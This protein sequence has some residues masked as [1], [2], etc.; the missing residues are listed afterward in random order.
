MNFLHNTHQIRYFFLIVIPLTI[1]YSIAG[2]TTISR[3]KE[4]YITELE[5]VESNNLEMRIRLF[6][7]TLIGYL[8]DA[9][10]LTEATGKAIDTAHEGEDVFEFLTTIFKAYACHHQAYDQIRYIDQNGMEKIRI[11]W[12]AAT[13]ARQAPENE[14]QYKGDRYYFLRGNTLPLGKVYLSALDLNIERGTIEIPIKP[15]MRIVLPVN[16]ADG[17]QKGILVMNLLGQKLIDTLTEAGHK[18]SGRLFLVNNKGHWLKGPEP[19]LEWQF[20]YSSTPETVKTKYPDL[21]KQMVDKPQGYWQSDSGLFYYQNISLGISP[22][23]T[24][25]DDP[26]VES[27]E[28]LQVINHIPPHLLSP[29]WMKPVLLLFFSGEVSLT[30]LSWIGA[31]LLTRRRLAIKS[32]AAKEKELTTIA[33]SVRDAI[34]MIDDSGRA[35]FWNSSAEELFGYPASEVL[36]RDIHQFITPKEQRP[37]ASAGLEEF[38]NTGEG[39][40]IGEL[41]KVEA[42]RK[43]G[44]RFPAE[45]N[46]NAIHMEDRWWAVGVVRDISS[47]ESIEKKAAIQEQ[48][49]K[50][51]VKYVPAAVAMFDRQICYIAASNRWYTDY[52]LEGQEIIGKS[53]YDIFPE[54]REMKEWLDLHQRCLSGEVLQRDEDDFIRADGH[55][56]WLRWE[57]RPWLD[58][59]GEIGGI[60]MLTEVITQRKEME[61]RIMES[62]QQLRRAMEEAPHPVM[63]RTGDGEI[64]LI[65]QPWLDLSGF[66][67]DQ[68]SNVGEWLER[69]YRETPDESLD[70]VYQLY[71]ISQKTDRGETQIL[72]V[73]GE[74]RDWEVS[75]ATIGQLPDGRLA[76]ITMAVDV[77]ERKKAESKVLALNRELEER[78]RQRTR[79]LEDLVEEIGKNERMVKL[80]GDVASTANTASSADQALMETLKLITAY[81]KWPLAHV[82]RT[83]KANPTV[84]VQAPLWYAPVPERFQRIIENMKHIRYQPGEGLPGQVYISGKACWIEDI[85]GNGDYPEPVGFKPEGIRGCFAFPVISRGEVL[86]VMEFFSL[87]KEAR[88]ETLLKMADEVGKQLGYVIERKRL[89]KAMEESERK[90]RGIFDQSSHFMGLVNTDGIL[91]QVNKAALKMIEKS[92]EEIVGKLFW[93]CPW[94]RHSEAVTRNIRKA[95]ETVCQGGSVRF[96]TSYLDGKDQVRDLDFALT[97]IAHDSGKVLYMIPE[98]RD[99]TDRKQAE[100]EAKK[101]A[102]VAEKTTTGIVITQADG[103]VEWLNRGFEQISEYT[104][105]ELYGKEPGSLLQGEETNREI[106]A[107]I[108]KS[109][110]K[111]EG[112]KT[113]LLNYRKSG[114][115]YWVELDIQPLFSEDGKLMKYISMQTDVTER[116]RTQD[117]LR[118]F[119]TTLDQTHDAVFIFDPDSLIFSYVN[120][121]AVLQLGYTRE[122]LQ[123]M[124]PVD[125]KPEFT[126]KRFMDMVAP[127]ISGDEKRLVF[128]T[129]HAHKDGRRIPVNILL[130]LIQEEKG[131]ARFVAI[132]RDVTEQKR[133]NL[134]LEAAKEAA[135][136]AARTKGEFL[137][138]MSHEIRTPMNAIIGMAYLAGNTDLTPRQKDYI[139]KIETSAKSLLAIINDI[140]D[141]SKI[142]AGRMTIEQVPFDL[143]EVINDIVTLSASPIAEKELELYVLIDPEISPI[144]NGD[145]VRLGQVLNNLL[146]NAVKFT[147]QGDIEIHVRRKEQ[148]SHTQVLEFELC[149]TGI[150]MTPDQT[151]RLFQKFSQADSAITRKYGGTGLG[152]AI[153][154]QLVRLMGGDIWVDSKIDEGSRFIFTLPLGY[155]DDRQSLATVHT[156]PLNLRDLKV[157]LMDGNPKTLS[158]MEQQLR[159]LNFEVISE[160]SCSLGVGAIEVSL[161]AK[162]PFELVVMDY[163]NCK[164]ESLTT[165]RRIWKILESMRIPTIIMVGLKELVEAEN[166]SNTIPMTSILSKPVTPSNLFNAI[167]DAFGYQDVKHR[168]E[169]EPSHSDTMRLNVLKG[170]RVL[171]VED[172]AMNQ[173]VAKELLEKVGVLVAIAKDGTQALKMV[174]S[175][176][177]DLILMDIQMPKMDGITA[178]GKIREMNGKIASIPIIAMTANAMVGDRQKSLN[179]GMNDHISKPV[180]PRK[181]YACMI[182]WVDG[183]SDSEVQ[184]AVLDSEDGL[185]L[186]VAE[187]LPGLDVATALTRLGGNVSLYDSLLREFLDTYDGVAGRILKNVQDGD[188]ETAIQEV[189]TAKGLSGTIGA[190]NLYQAFR[191]VE[192]ALK[193]KD[194]SLEVELENLNKMFEQALVVISKALPLTVKDKTGGQTSHNPIKET[195]LAGNLEKLLSLIRSNDMKSEELFNEIRHPLGELF[196]TQTERIRE[197]IASLDFKTVVILLEPIVQELK[198]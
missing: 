143:T 51:F 117:T 4:V 48:Q 88:D 132:V 97:P 169:S 175:A 194:K 187:K 61:A 57:L 78:V 95:V 188:D 135:E 167:V 41:R 11:N 68:I 44:S 33:N 64:L 60:M 84:L 183:K 186:G 191:N 106:V 21:W 174:Q 125:I 113:E 190:M 104:L 168:R 32:L 70:K 90:F 126:H 193:E 159:S 65:N 131:P 177:Y 109:L 46:L 83:L 63:V 9:A 27:Q 151:A 120:L 164:E 8:E 99:I 111:G 166:I 71:E 49:L 73:D 155:Q 36:E 122:E 19:D 35:L 136:E 40:F 58:D 172:N 59:E 45:L 150:G 153:C 42:L 82:Y 108:S 52:G 17:G 144:V 130:Q 43:D 86:A 189:H 98:G 30:L 128:E 142:E 163:K 22:D 31:G 180:D 80:L 13:G 20:M 156:L 76:G 195:E 119:K 105:K 55:T 47:R 185:E 149:D 1:L 102:L 77:T 141:F 179:A 196:P 147:D 50:T 160:S 114:E 116:K 124:T 146:S 115:P 182:R 23:K 178:T 10:I 85:S 112:I 38:S 184:M 103:C 162:T 94:W 29:S 198:K 6:E 197:A 96:E 127:L 181:L 138:N 107:Q 26:R 14:L 74:H 157:L 24:K 161:N 79:R 148:Y 3:Q 28:S 134:E 145:P 154:R 87:S 15:V 7:S 37:E 54:I 5:L 2:W 91:L 66:T 62:E 176:S 118:Q 39:R 101:L 110:E 72:T 92:Q 81:V 158:I 133:I 93:E 75:T 100:A 67:R 140:L 89:E 34:V 69:A 18:L 16:S 12:S 121:G 129:V 170:A 139:G 53:H 165:D 192:L 171:L 25:V 152:L 56:E 173:Q 123:T 137:A